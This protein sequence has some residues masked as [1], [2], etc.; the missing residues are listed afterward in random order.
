MIRGDF[1]TGGR[2]VLQGGVI[3]P[4]LSLREEG[5]GS[6]PVGGEGIETIEFGATKRARSA[7][8]RDVPHRASRLILKRGKRNSR[9]NGGGA[10]VHKGEFRV[11]KDIGIGIVE[12]IF[13]IVNDKKIFIVEIFDIVDAANEFGRRKE[14]NVTT[15][16]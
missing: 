2:E 15:G 14:M 12:L 10:S 5:G 9:A 11:V 7:D 16:A 8:A 4:D 1:G 3:D 13:G 6:S